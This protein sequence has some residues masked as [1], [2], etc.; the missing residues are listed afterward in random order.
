MP[1]NSKAL[2]D[3]SAIVE[4]LKGNSNCL[5]MQ[6][7][8]NE[9]LLCVND[10]VLAE[11]LPAMI[12]KEKYLQADFIRKLPQLTM[13]TNWEEIINYQTILMKNGYFKIGISDLLIAQ[14]CI[15]NDISIISCDK[16]FSTI[17][18]YFPLKLY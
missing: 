8:S 1:L 5:F 4:F 2:V 13:N 18:K 11:L 15:Q 16:H 9:Q 6:N 12:A 14:N 7:L 17:A 10:V 3:S